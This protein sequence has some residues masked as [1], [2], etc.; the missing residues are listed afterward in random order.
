MEP[1]FRTIIGQIFSVENEEYLKFKIDHK[2]IE[3]LLKLNSIIK[4]NLS[5][6]QL[7]LKFV[8]QEMA[9]SRSQL[10][11]MITAATGKS[12]VAYINSYKLS[13]ALELIR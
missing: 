2:K 13:K 6:N 8:F 10:Y 5:N 4:E 11:R 9:V 12:V 7:S 1:H 3:C